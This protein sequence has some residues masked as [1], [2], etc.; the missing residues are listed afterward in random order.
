MEGF[1][2]YLYSKGIIKLPEM[3]KRFPNG[4]TIK[5]FAEFKDGVKIKNMFPVWNDDNSLLENE[6]NYYLF[7]DLP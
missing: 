3:S 4:K 5:C 7:E 6:H 1:A 2:N